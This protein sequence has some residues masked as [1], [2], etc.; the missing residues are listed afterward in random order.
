MLSR[1]DLGRRNLGAAVAALLL[2]GAAP[3]TL[4]AQDGTPS[5]PQNLEAEAG[6]T[7]VKITWDPPADDG[8]SALTGYQFRGGLVTSWLPAPPT[9]T[10]PATFSSL[11]NGTEYTFEVRAVNANG[12][13]AVASVKATP[14]GAPSGPR[15]TWRRPREMAR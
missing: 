14:R 2:C 13:G 11:T 10:G 4:Q 8:G 6:D 5:A 15:R 3:A 12:E 7:W 9:E 1:L